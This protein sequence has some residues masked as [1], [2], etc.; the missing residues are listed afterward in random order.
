MQEDVSADSGTEGRR[1]EPCQ[2][3]HTL[4]VVLS[5]RIPTAFAVI[6]RS[7]GGLHSL[8]V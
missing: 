7:F 1:F 8:P 4:R 5:L 2:A 6:K 3:Y